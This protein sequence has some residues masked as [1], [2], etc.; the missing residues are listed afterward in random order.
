MK[1]PS[2]ALLCRGKEFV[3]GERT[4]VV[5]IINVTPDSFSG[6]GVMDVQAVVDQGK[7]FVEEGTHF[8]DVGGESTRPPFGARVEAGLSGAEW[9]HEVGVVSME[10]ELSRV[11]PVIKR[12][13][14][15]VDI[16]ISID[17]YKAEVARQALEAGATMINDVWGLKADP[18]V[19][20]VAAEYN[21]PLVLMHNQ[22]GRQ[23]ENLM[24][25]IRAS[26]ETSAQQAL[27]AGVSPQNI[28]LDPGFGFGKMPVHN[29]EVLRR[30]GELKEMG[31]PLLVGTSRKSTIGLVLDLPVY[32]RVEGTAA[33]V[34]I[35]IANGADIV[36]VHDVKAMARVARMTDAVVRG[37]DP[38]PEA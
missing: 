2:R 37:W 30:L 33:T 25:D 13:A 17:T 32:E 35:A 19:A 6:D 4:Y 7:R 1:Y 29:L 8:L 28:V 14:G 26:L 34:A 18:N 5:G 36:R 21:V 20:A 38:R 22:R 15:E 23:Y 27:D 24:P 10:E 11:L 9:G 12:L 31:Y 16:P 3:W